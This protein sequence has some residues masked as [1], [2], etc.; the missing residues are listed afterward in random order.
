MQSRTIKREI[1]IAAALFAVGLLLL[2]VAIYWVGRQVAGEYGGGALALADQIWA[3]LLQL[4]PAACLLVL[5]PYLLL[6]IVR[7]IGRTWRARSV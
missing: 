7:L 2:P 4:D 5:S 1:A 3:D 6:Q